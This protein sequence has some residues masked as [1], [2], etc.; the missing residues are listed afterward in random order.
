M[1]KLSISLCILLA[2]VG[3]QVAQ[4]SAETSV[5][6]EPIKQNALTT[7]APL[8]IGSVTQ[9][10]DTYGFPGSGTAGDP[11]IIS[12]LSIES[13]TAQALIEIKNLQVH[14][15]IT[16]NFLNASGLTYHGI[17]LEDVSNVQ[18]ISNDIYA[19]E[20]VSAF[21]ASAVSIFGDSSNNRVVE[22]HIQDSDYGVYVQSVSGSI[23]G[24]RNNTI[25]NN[26]FDNIFN[27]GVKIDAVV[28]NLVLLNNSIILNNFTNAN[29]GIYVEASFSTNGVSDHLIKDNTFLD[30]GTAIYLVAQGNDHLYPGLNRNVK[31][32]NNTIIRSLYQGI[33]IVRHSFNTIANNSIIDGEDE[34][35]YLYSTTNNTITNNT[36]FKNAKHGIH[37][38]YRY[39]Q[40]NTIANN[41]IAN[42]SLNEFYQGIFFA[43]DTKNNF[44]INNT[45]A[46]NTSFGVTVNYN[47]DNYNYISGND[48]INNNGGLTQANSRALNTFEY[49]YWDDW[50]EPDVNSDGIV[51]LP[52]IISSTYNVEDSFPLTEKN[53]A[54]VILHSLTGLELISPNGGEN[55][56]GAVQISWNPAAD[57]EG[58]S[59]SYNVSY[60]AD[61]GVSWNLLQ[62]DLST[63]V[64]SWDTTILST[65]SSYLIMVSADDSTGLVLEDVSDAVFSIANPVPITSTP[66]EPTTPP[67]TSSPTPTPS[68]TIITTS[69]TPTS[70]TPTSTTPS[71]TTTSTTTTTSIGSDTSNTDD[72][73][74]LLLLGSMV[75]LSGI[76]LIRRKR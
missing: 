68:D 2:L 34:A 73:P 72:Q 62:S 57:T 31:I 42:N 52:Y 53:N 76:V 21:L 17:Y 15:V 20:T 29:T 35:M 46:N 66:T 6:Q 26:Q 25:Y 12:G 75:I 7:H 45:I 67:P 41:V 63:T 48:F 47:S 60:S 32:L 56:I 50:T 30:S 23:T 54:A 61:N 3:F 65:G 71:P 24:P 5:G 18:I 37:L 27:T 14:I 59:I 64:L 39:T 40:N 9:I 11:Y 10:T 8:L 33:A 58:H 51:D 38:N 69:S 49:N 70:S 13:T 4:Y 19:R 1:K 16:G 44:V 55:L 43:A 28:D 22:N 36:I 74:I